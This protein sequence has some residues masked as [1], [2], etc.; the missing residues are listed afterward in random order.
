LTLFFLVLFQEI[1]LTVSNEYT[2]WTRNPSSIHA[3]DIFESLV[4]LLSDSTVVAPLIRTGIL[5]SKHRKNTY[6]YEFAH[7]TERGDFPS[8]LGCIMG[9][10]LA[11]FFGAPLVPGMQLGY[12]PAT[13]TRQ[14]AVFTEMVMTYLGNF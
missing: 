8:H 6:F 13:F 14:E 10:D 12:F 11:Y 2:D 4:E 1:L 5:H 7:A 3:T 9:D